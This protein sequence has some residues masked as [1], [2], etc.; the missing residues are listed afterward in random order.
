[1]SKIIMFNKYEILTMHIYKDTCL[2][3][4]S[5]KLQL[6]ISLNRGTEIEIINVLHK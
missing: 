2:S 5:Y 1:M 4:C 3:M 6:R